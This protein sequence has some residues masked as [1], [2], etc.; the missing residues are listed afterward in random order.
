MTPHVA[1]LGDALLLEVS[2]S[3]RLW[4]GAAALQR[5]IFEENPALAS[6]N[7]AQA[8]I[9]IIALAH[10]RLRRDGRGVPAGGV[11]ALPLSV[12]D[13]AR[14][15]LPLL[16]RLGLRT[17]GDAHALPRAPMVRRFGPGL[18]VPHLG[19]NALE[20]RPSSPLWKGIPPG[21]YFYF[22]HSYYAEPAKPEVI[23]GITGY[24]GPVPAAIGSGM[25]HAVQFHPEK[26][27]QHGLQL[28]RNFITL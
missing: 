21:S 11:A 16:E 10:L 2:G 4:G 12:L 14:L 25:I 28:L 5:R 18:K 20:Q 19:W 17:W 7:I 26:S 8:A 27:Q 23:A 3:L 22:A 15:H 13:A 24:G 6:A 1:R 9:G